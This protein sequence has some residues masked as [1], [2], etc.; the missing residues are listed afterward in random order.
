LKLSNS[1]YD[2]KLDLPGSYAPLLG[3][4]QGRFGEFSR[5]L[6][7]SSFQEGKFRIAAKTPPAR[8]ALGWLAENP[9][10]G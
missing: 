3:E 2:P 10:S 5:Y 7:L 1:K 8:P 9:A 6:W 4:N